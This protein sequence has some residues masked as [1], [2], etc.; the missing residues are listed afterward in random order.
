MDVT[1][2]R[3]VLEQRYNLREQVDEEQ[4]QNAMV[5]LGQYLNKMFCIHSV[6][7][8]EPRTIDFRLDKIRDRIGAV[9][10]LYHLLDRWFEEMERCERL[11]VDANRLRCDVK[12]FEQEKEQKD[13]QWREKMKHLNDQGDYWKSK[14]QDHVKAS[15]SSKRQIKEFRTEISLQKQSVKRLQRELRKSKL[16]NAQMLEPVH[17]L[18]R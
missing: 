1:V 11:R 12:H 17:T 4:W 13:Y 16:Q 7:C 2:W 9:L 18:R 8:P 10:T 5:N 14:Y 3:D 15:E 6:W